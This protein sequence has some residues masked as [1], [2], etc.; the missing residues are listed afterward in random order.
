M[1]KR[2]SYIFMSLRSA[3]AT[4][5]K[6]LEQTYTNP[7]VTKM[8]RTRKSFAISLYSNRSR[9]SRAT[10][11]NSF[12]SPSQLYSPLGS[13]EED[14]ELYIRTEGSLANEVGLTVI[15]TVEMF[16]DRFKV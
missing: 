10:S 12:L 11:S 13:E 1:Y 14:M 5:L 7:I 15:E 4:M 2:T 9:M 6:Q 8:S 16:T 3:R